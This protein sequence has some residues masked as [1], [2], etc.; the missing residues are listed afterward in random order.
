[1]R[2]KSKWKPAVLI[3]F[4]IHVVIIGIFGFL[5]PWI[6]GSA[7]AQPS[8][9]TVEYSAGDGTDGDGGDGSN[10]D[11]QQDEQKDEPKDEQ[12][13]ETPQPTQ[14]PVTPV[15]ETVTSP[16]T[17]TD[18]YNALVTKSAQNGQPS[19]TKSTGGGKK[20]NGG[21]GGQKR[22]N[23]PIT[24]HTEYPPRGIVKFKGYITVQAYINTDGKVPRG[25]LMTPVRDRNNPE[26]NRIN[27]L[28]VEYAKKWLFKPATD[29]NGN[30]IASYKNIS[31][32]FNS[33]PKLEKE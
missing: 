6:E 4:A 19:V 15:P 33:P 3:A 32:P 10:Q 18:P 31:I 7:D 23:P 5:V 27:S 9:P 24:E 12:K 29:E 22:G 13:E 16:V 20:G 26:M 21:G 25:K 14:E 28:A 11:E 1:M 2:F 8:E 30:P 17:A